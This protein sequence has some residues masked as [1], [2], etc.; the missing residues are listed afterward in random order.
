MYAFMAA[1]NLVMSIYL[2]Q[3]YG[4]I[5]SAIGTAFSLIVANGI[6]MNVYYYYKCGVNTIAFWKSI[7][8]MSRGLIIPIIAGIIFNY[9]SN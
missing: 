6:I 8:K 1:I 4:A 9:L 3:L 5:G 7:I 2:C